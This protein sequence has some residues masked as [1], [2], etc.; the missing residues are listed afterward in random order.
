MNTAPFAV[1]TLRPTDWTNADGVVYPSL[2]RLYMEYSDPTEFQ[3][4]RDNLESFQHWLAITEHPDLEPTIQKWR[5]ELELKIKAQV[6]SG[7]MQLALDTSHSKSLEASKFLFT[8]VF[9]SLR[10]GRRKSS[11][12]IDVSKTDV[13]EKLTKSENST[14]K[15]DFERLKSMNRSREAISPL[16]FQACQPRLPVRN[17]S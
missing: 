9:D 17:S 11:A 12:A 14:F 6:L 7:I 1:Y 3:F 13:I 16:I 15:A 2:Y 10:E 8:S 4:A 5:V